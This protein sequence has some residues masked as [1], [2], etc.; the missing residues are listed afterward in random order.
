MSL[1]PQLFHCIYQCLGLPEPENQMAPASLQARG[2]PVPALSVLCL[3]LHSVTP[4]Q[5]G[6]ST[7]KTPMC[8][9]PPQ[10]AE[11]GGGADTGPCAFSKTSFH[12][13]AP[14]KH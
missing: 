9:L 12:L 1:H 5:C 8:I 2:A 3:R 13:C 4:R 7:V 14:V 6:V 11:L 10:V